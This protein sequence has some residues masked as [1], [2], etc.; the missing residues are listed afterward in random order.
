[1]PTEGQ[2]LYKSRDEIYEDMAVELQTR[3]PDAFL[4][5]EGN[6]RML[7]EIVAG[8]AESIYLA[9]QIVSDDQFIQ[10]ANPVALDRHGDERGVPR[11]PG[12]PATGT[13]KISGEGGTV[14]NAGS[15]CAFDPGTGVDPLYFLTQA[16]VTIPN[17][18]LLTA[19]VIS[20]NGAGGSLAAGTYE[21]GYT[22][23]SA[24][25]ETALSPVSNALTIA[26]NRIIY[27]STIPQGGPG[28]TGRS[29]YRR[30][31][32]GAWVKLITIPHNNF[33][34]SSDNGSAPLGG[35][36]PEVS[37]AEVISV[38][39]QSESAGADYNVL[40]GTITILTDA[41]DGVTSVTN[42]AAF[43]GGTDPED[44]EDYRIRLLNAIRNPSTGSANDLKSWA[45]SNPLVESATVFQNDNMGT[46][47]NGHVTI[48]ISSP[49]G[50]IP[51]AQLLTDV[52]ADLNAKDLANITLHT[53]SFTAVP[54]NVSVTTTPTTGYVLADISPGVTQ[55]ISNYINALNVGETVRVAGL[56][57]AVFGLPGLD[58]VVVTVPASNQVTGATQKRTVGTITVS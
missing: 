33:S 29:I 51:S 11:L 54:T 10:T 23:L 49:G 36:P 27:L 32:G 56:V 2:P 1:V 37:T 18:G 3:V 5:E 42:P 16:L 17:L 47:A 8:I 30:K 28:T 13:L 52:L 24:I 26:A 35:T 46:P 14:I 41:P 22:L 40:P 9:N 12:T 45:E 43:V 44:T 25:G 55:A 38:A 48:R 31:D 4:G 39:A 7:F 20:D 50:Q 15:E 58:D 57:D 19:L 34:T 53:A 21:Y 6:L